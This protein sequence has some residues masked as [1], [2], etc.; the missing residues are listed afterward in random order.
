MFKASSFTVWR[1][2][3]YIQCNIKPLLREKKFNFFFVLRCVQYYS[4]DW[5]LIRVMAR[6]LNAYYVMMTMMRYYC[7]YRK[8]QS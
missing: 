5:V 6:A 4:V 1:L 7:F 3:K 8:S 2:I